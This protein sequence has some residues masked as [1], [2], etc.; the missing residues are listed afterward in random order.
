VLPAGAAA[1]QAPDV[2]R[3][4]GDDDSAEPMG[5]RP[6]SLP[7]PPKRSSTRPKRPRRRSDA[8]DETPSEG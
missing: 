7:K 6:A 4:G 1:P 3:A 5:E 8:A 2:Q